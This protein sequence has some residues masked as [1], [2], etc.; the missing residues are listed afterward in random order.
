MKKILIKF[1]HVKKTFSKNIVL[2]DINFEIDEGKIIGILGFSGCGKTTILNMLCGYQLPDSGNILYCI[3]KG[4]QE[5][6][7]PILQIHDYFKSKIGYSTQE[8][9]FYPDLTVSENMKYFASLYY[10]TDMQCEQATQ[11]LLNNF[12]L[13]GHENTIAR[14]LS[15]GMK[16]RLDLSCSLIHKPEILIL[17]EP[18]A[19][20][21]FKLSEDF[22]KYIKKI[23]KKGVTIIFVSHLLNEISEVCDQVIMVKGKSETINVSGDIKKH[24]EHFIEKIEKEEKQEEK[25][26][27]KQAKEE[28]EKE[29]KHKEKNSQH[30]TQ[31]EGRRTMKFNK[32]I[33]K[34]FKILFR[35]KISLIIL[36][37]SPLLVIFLLGILFNNYNLYNI[38]VGYTELHQNELNSQYISILKSNF[39]LIEYQSTA[40]CIKSVEQGFSHVCIFF[41]GNDTTSKLQIKIDSTKKN[42]QNIVEKL[43]LGTIDS[44]TKNYQINNTETLINIIS[45]SETNSLKNIEKIDNLTKQIDELKVQESIFAAQIKRIQGTFNVE[46]FEIDKFHQ[47]SEKII[48]HI[49]AFLDE[50]YTQI[51]D[52][53]HSIQEISTI[54]K[55]LNYSSGEDEDT[56]KDNIDS[57][58]KKLNDLR[59][60]T[61]SLKQKSTDEEL[62][63]E[64]TKLSSDLEDINSI[65]TKATANLE[66]VKQTFTNSNLNL[67]NNMS[68]IVANNENLL[69][70][71]SD[72][73][74]RNLS[75][76]NRTIRNRN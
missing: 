65:L 26:E 28:A 76:H 33:M 31:Q 69:Q 63:E 47:S 67:K 72:I 46:D 9:S 2:K 30:K 35:K 6:F 58:E 74:I 38:N 48:E 49:D 8:P 55:E 7:V 56:V 66:E 11:E 24:F 70:S 12:D 40:D 34:N 20:L 61:Y 19:N 59:D 16:K 41:T 4:Y 27:K 36:L 21:D 51:S 18:T 29:E 32:L 25:Q 22:I 43:V 14:N 17:D 57:I 53:E 10:M 3:K 23:N 68:Q 75:T 1:E 54:T 37:V 73:K 39:N 50:S 13:K 42:M 71:I 62:S 44:Q 5:K 45:Q 52:M 15:E 64:I 60:E